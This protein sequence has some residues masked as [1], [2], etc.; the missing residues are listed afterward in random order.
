MYRQRQICHQLT[1]AEGL[2]RVRRGLE[3]AGLS[4]RSA[5]A[6]Q[7]CAEFGFEGARGQ[8]QLASCMQ[9]PRHLE[10]EQHIALPSSTHAAVSWGVRRLPLQPSQSPQPANCARILAAARKLAQRL[11]ETCPD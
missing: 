5:L 8:L 2:A 3:E 10:R 4:T 11:I 1:S 9:A 6:R 7:V